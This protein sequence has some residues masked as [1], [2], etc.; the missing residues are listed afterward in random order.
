[1]IEKIDIKKKVYGKNSFTNVIDTN[2]KQLITPVTE[3]ILSV[4]ESI[5]SFFQSYDS[6]FFDISPSGSDQSHLELVSRSSD[7]LGISIS[8]M[9]EEIRVLRE[10]NVSLKNQ[11]FNSSFGNQNIIKG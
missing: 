9:Q 10:E 1:M 8:D 11:L 4:T 5:N 3:V 7:Y 2:F 6:L